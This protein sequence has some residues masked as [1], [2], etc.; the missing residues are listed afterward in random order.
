MISPLRLLSV[1]MTDIRRQDFKSPLQSA[2][3][4]KQFNTCDIDISI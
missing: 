3:K 4:Q 1:K 2:E